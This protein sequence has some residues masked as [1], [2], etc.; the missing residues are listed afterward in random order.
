VDSKFYSMYVIG[1]Y[2]FIVLKEVPSSGED[3]W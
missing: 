1:D 3:K 2:G